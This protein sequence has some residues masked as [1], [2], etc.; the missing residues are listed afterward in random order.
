MRDAFYNFPGDVAIIHDM[1]KHNEQLRGVL[2]DAEI[3]DSRASYSLTYEKRC[4]QMYVSRN[5]EFLHSTDK[6]SRKTRLRNKHV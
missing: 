4:Y 3:R 2:H 1:V 6:K 5:D